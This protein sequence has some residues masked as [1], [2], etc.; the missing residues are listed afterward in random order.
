M[1]ECDRPSAYPSTGLSTGEVSLVF[2]NLYSCPLPVSDRNISRRQMLAAVGITGVLAGC[3][4]TSDQ[5]SDPSSEETPSEQMSDFIYVAPDGDDGNPG[6]E[7]E[8]IN[9][10]M[11]AL[12]MVEPGQTIY[13]KPGE[14]RGRVAT[15]HS[16]EPEN[17]ITITGPKDAVIRPSKGVDEK[18]WNPIVIQHSHYRLTGVTINGLHTP[19]APEQVDS[20]VKRLLKVTPRPESSE[21]VEDVVIAPHGIGN[22]QTQLINVIRAKNC[23]FG[24]FK[25]I[26]PAGVEYLYGDKVSHQGEILYIGSPLQV[27]A[28]G[29]DGYFWDEYDKTRNIH[30]H[31]IDNSEG[32]HHSEIVDCKDG[33]ENITIEYCTDA[34]GSRN[35]EPYSAQSVHMRGHNCTVRWNRLADGAG[36]GIEVYKPGSNELYP[37]FGFDERVVDRIAIENEIYGNEIR[38]F[39]KKAIAFD[40][41]TRDAQRRVC[42][43]DIRGDTNGE[44]KKQ[45]P[46]TL[47]KGDGIGHTGGDSPW[48]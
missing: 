7:N 27:Y 32:Y 21:Y 18:H 42:G 33:T 1:S 45:C 8:P 11:T 23:E 41:G 44:P 26:G 17:P 30:I 15:I 6:T 43:N 25:M 2:I 28:D 13:L 48:S 5:E 20:Y 16:G 35:N 4:D 31:H 38:D 12:D 9:T 19:D 24:P 34:G 14:Y 46:E 29:A 40:E 3:A 39:E 47:P 22:S 37:E 10:I 36:N